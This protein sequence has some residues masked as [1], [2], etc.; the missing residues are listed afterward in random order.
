[1]VL[2]VSSYNHFAMLVLCVSLI[3]S[4]YLTWCRF[5]FEPRRHD[6]TRAFMYPSCSVIQ[7]NAIFDCAKDR[8]SLKVLTLMGDVI[9]DVGI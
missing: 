4:K 6:L 7:E 1:V 3:L 9:L 8:F 5:A 2:Q